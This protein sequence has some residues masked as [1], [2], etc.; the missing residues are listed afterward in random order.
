MVVS[1]KHS[2]RTVLDCCRCRQLRDSRLARRRGVLR[3]RFRELVA[4]GGPFGSGDFAGFIVNIFGSSAA[5]RFE[6]SRTLNHHTLYE[7]GF[8]VPQN[9]SNYAIETTNGPIATAYSGSFL[10]DPQT[11]DLVE[12]TVRTADLALPDACQAASSI[13]YQRVA[14]HGQ[15]V[16]IPN[17]TDLRAVFRDGTEAVGVTTHST[18][19]E[20]ASHTRLLLRCRGCFH[21]GGRAPHA[22][23]RVAPTRAGFSSSDRNA[24]RFR[25]ISRSVNRSSSTR[26]AY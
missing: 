7:Y 21:Q 3:R 11:A 22:K 2:Q 5:I 4:N 25:L 6:Q 15:D 23:T 13:R 14:I 24:V 9:A 1:G 26:S 8:E 17:E 10:I 16:L 20:Y 18:C 12:L 19:H